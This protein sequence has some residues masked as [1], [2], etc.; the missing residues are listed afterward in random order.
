[1]FGIACVCCSGASSSE[2]GGGNEYQRGSA[3]VVSAEML[4]KAFR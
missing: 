4:E 2:S 1:M 3:T